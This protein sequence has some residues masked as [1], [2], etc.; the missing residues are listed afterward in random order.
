MFSFLPFERR[1]NE[2]E[3]K[4]NETEI[5][6]NNSDVYAL[7]L[8]STLYSLHFH[9]KLT[10]ISLIHLRGVIYYF[11]SLMLTSIQYDPKWRYGTN[12]IRASPTH[13]SITGA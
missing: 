2:Q 6:T 3:I 9:Y 7:L 10:D 12:N 4:G 1:I 5:K 8:I 11:V 13:V